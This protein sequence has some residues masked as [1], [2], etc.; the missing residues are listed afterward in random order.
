M[1]SD[2]RIVVLELRFRIAGGKY[3]CGRIAAA[4]QK[5]CDAAPY[6]RF[7]VALSVEKA[8]PRGFHETDALAK[9]Y[10]GGRI[11]DLLSATVELK[12]AALLSLRLQ[13][14]GISAVGLNIHEAGVQLV[15]QDSNVNAQIRVE[16]RWLQDALLENYVVVVPG[17]FATNAVGSIVSLGPNGADLSAAV[18][19]QKLD[20]DRWEM[21]RSVS[22]GVVCDPHNAKTKPSGNSQFTVN[23][24]AF[25]I[26]TEARIPLLVRDL[27]R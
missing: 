16:V 6:E 20:A 4:L 12:W 1:C 24:V 7:V 8:A 15:S 25:Q 27:E 9:G 3:E 21:I 11:F 26:A 13:R 17:S 5:R 10:P 23:S 22:G 19:A 14:C 18:L 2:Y